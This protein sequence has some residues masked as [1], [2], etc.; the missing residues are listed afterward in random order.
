[1]NEFA[2]RIL[3]AVDP[4]EQ[5]RQQLEE[6]VSS[7]GKILN[8]LVKNSRGQMGLV[9]DQMKNSPEYR[10]AKANYDRAFR[11]L[12]QFNTR[13]KPKRRERFGPDGKPRY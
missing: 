9:S 6:E 7:T 11:A 12:R 5:K 1:M 10:A 3:S 2:K 8:D 4:I 13:Y